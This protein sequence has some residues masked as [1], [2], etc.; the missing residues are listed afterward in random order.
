MEGE[1]ERLKEGEKEVRAE[2]T[3]DGKEGMVL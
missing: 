1:S 3:K 2:E